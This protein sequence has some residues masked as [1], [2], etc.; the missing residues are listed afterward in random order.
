[1]NTTANRLLRR[2]LTAIL[3][4]MA[5]MSCATAYTQEADT[6]PAHTATATM[7][8][9]SVLKGAPTFT[10]VDLATP[11]GTLNIPLEDLAEIRF[12]PADDATR[13]V[14]GLASRDRISG[15]LSAKQLNL[16]SPYGPLELPV[17]DILR[18]TFA[19]AGGEKAWADSLS[20]GLLLHYTFDG[21]GAAA[22]HDQSGQMNHARAPRPPTLTD[23]GHTGKALVCDGGASFLSFPA[24]PTLT[25]TRF[26]FSAWIKPR[27]AQHAPLLEFSSNNYRYGPHVWSTHDGRLYMN[28]WGR[29]ANDRVV[30]TPAQQLPVGEWT[31]I[32]CVYDGARGIVYVNGV[33]SAAQSFA[34][35]NI[36]L[37]HPFYVGARQGWS[38]GNVVFDGLVDEVRV[39]TRALT[40]DEV[41]LL[42]AP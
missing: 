33:E 28:F 18:M 19:R 7:R 42:A 40:P 14:V 31:H 27:L 21:E 37:A 22:L 13:A 4:A 36:D 24:T 29:P 35:L 39:Y 25:T 17:R 38:N 6:R 26:S 12:E 23:E 11:H 9:G 15:E 1:M 16:A 8:N 3:P 34:D 30:N 20:D 10:R 41:R 5:T 32:A 2:T